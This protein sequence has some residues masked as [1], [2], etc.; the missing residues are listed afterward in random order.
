MC[1]R[2]EVLLPG[3]TRFAGRLCSREASTAADI[4]AAME[5]VGGAAVGEAGGVGCRAHL[6]VSDVHEGKQVCIGWWVDHLLGG[7]RGMQRWEEGGHGLQCS[8]Q[9]VVAKKIFN[10]WATQKG[11]WPAGASRARGGAQA[12]ELPLLPHTAPSLAPFT[13]TPPPAGPPPARGGHH[14]EGPGQPLVSQ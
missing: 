14:G 10:R 4:Q 3:K 7:R 9:Y 5:E 11:C 8:R 1:G 6:R 12:L 2:V 13:W